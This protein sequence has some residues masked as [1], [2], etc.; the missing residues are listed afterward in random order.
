MRGVATIVFIEVEYQPLC[1]DW[2]TLRDYP[3]LEHNARKH[4]ITCAESRTRGWPQKSS[5]VMDRKSD[6]NLMH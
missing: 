3:Y 6:S 4:G 5:I 1:L 2:V